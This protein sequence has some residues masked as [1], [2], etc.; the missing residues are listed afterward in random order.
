MGCKSRTCEDRNVYIRSK[1]TGGS[2]VPEHREA[3]ENDK[4]NGPEYAPHGQIWLQAVRVYEG[5]AVDAL[6]SQAIVW[7]CMSTGADKRNV[8]SNHSQ[9]PRYVRLIE[10]QEKKLPTADKLTSQVKA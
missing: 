6:G 9:K 2:E 3:I 1:E 5:L 8:T 10:N 7:I 4:D